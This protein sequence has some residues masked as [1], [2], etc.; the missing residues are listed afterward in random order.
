MAHSEQLILASSS[1]HRRALLERLRL[2]FRCHAPG[3]DETPQPGEAPPA[4]VERLA[5][6]KARA[7]A[8]FYP[9]ALIIGSDEVAALDGRIFPKPADPTAARRQLETMSGREVEFLTSVCLL[10]NATGRHQLDT[11][12][13]QVRFRPLTQAEIRRYLDIDK[14]YDCAGSFR[15]EAGGITLVHRISSNDNTALLGLPLITLQEM[16]RNEGYEIP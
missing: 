11:V 1:V 2:P 15:S 6:A 3:I 7:V 9:Q 12:A 14:P 8:R 10:N 5:L 16:L 4:L 13:V